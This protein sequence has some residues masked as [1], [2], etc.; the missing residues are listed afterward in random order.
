M[1]VAHRVLGVAVLGLAVAGVTAGVH[2]HGGATGIVKERMDA[3]GMMADSMKTI[4]GML[5]GK[6]AYDA[7]ALR[8]AARK[9][10]THGGDVLTRQF[11]EGSIM[12]PSE[13]RPEIWSDWA[14]FGELARDLSVRAAAVAE[15]ADDKAAVAPRFGM[16]GKT[17]S[18]CH[19]AFRLKKD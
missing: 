11:P 15:V 13:A 14:R 17:C 19:E 16:L 9:I 2:A 18:S 3:M 5:R 8:E 10:E 12:G 6:T 4:G 1:K 7:A